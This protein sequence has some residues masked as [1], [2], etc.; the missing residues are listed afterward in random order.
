MPR[1]M[2]EL[3]ASFSDNVDANISFALRAHS[4][5]SLSGDRSVWN[6]RDVWIAYEAAFLRIYGQWEG[7]IEA[8]FIR[9]MCGFASTGSSVRPVGLTFPSFSSAMRKLLGPGGKYLSW[10]DP[11]RVINRANRY[12]INSEIELVFRSAVSRLEHF[13]VI[14]HRIAHQTDDVKQQFHNTTM[15]L[16]GRRYSGATVGRFLRSQSHPTSSSSTW[17]ESI[18]QE[19]K[20]YARQIYP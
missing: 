20:L 5:R 17:L 2:P 7:L 19:L 9:Q 10:W 15:A 1:H 13:S 16:A 3:E 4:A 11:T 18:A 8:T 14:R 6:Y 12:L